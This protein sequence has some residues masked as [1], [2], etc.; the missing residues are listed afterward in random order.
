MKSVSLLLLSAAALAL[1]KRPQSIAFS[2]PEGDDKKHYDPDMAPETQNIPLDSAHAALRPPPPRVSATPDIFVGLSTFR[3][4]HRCGY[5]LFTGY[6]RAVHPD[7]LYFG[8]VDQVNPGDLRCLDE[9][10]KMANTE[11][12]EEECKYKAQIKIDERLADDSRGPTYARHHQQKL[13]G[14]QEFCLQLDAHSVFTNGWDP[15]LIDEWK[16]VGNEMAIL[17]TYLHHV[18]DGY[19]LSDGTNNPPDQ[20]PHLCTTMRGG[21]GCVRNVGA[22]MMQRP[23]MPQMQALWGAGLSFGK[24]HA[25]KRVLID[26][27]T[28]WMFDGEEFLRASH[29][30]TYGYDMYSPS[31]GGTVVYHNYTSVPARFEHV[32][33]DQARKA[34]EEKMGV[35]RFKLMVGQPFKGLV[36]TEEWDKYA[37]GTVRPFKAF[38]NFSGITFEEGKS[39]EHSCKQ[40]H[41]VPYANPAE[42]EALLPGWHLRPKKTHAPTTTTES[43]PVEVLSNNEAGERS[44][45]VAP[46][47]REKAPDHGIEATISLDHVPTMTGPV[48]FMLFG[49]VVFGVVMYSNDGLWLSTKRYFRLQ[50]KARN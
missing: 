20:L 50:H 12:P 14:D 36:D 28:L 46:T 9:Y 4:G 2:W 5:T 6:K 3:D 24:C 25:E 17:S 10:C 13:I 29:L 44:V 8:V 48:L 41:W 35:N 47:R 7:R 45:T 43:P 21:N 22:S 38:L 23:E 37:F 31:T 33:V 1:A 11:W 30:W 26:S 32:Q 49:V 34:K 27:H 15:S 42:I 19:V 18:H 40:L 16:S 39:D